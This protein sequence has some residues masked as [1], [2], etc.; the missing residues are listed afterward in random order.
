MQLLVSYGLVILLIWMANR[1]EV[2]KSLTLAN[3][4]EASRSL[5][6][7]ERLLRGVML[8]ISFFM[9]IYGLS[10][11]WG[12]YRK[13]VFVLSDWVVFAVGLVCAVCAW[14]LL[15]S[16]PM[17]LSL[18]HVF[19]HHYQPR[20][21]VHL[22]A[23]QIMIYAVGLSFIDYWVGGGLEGL[24]NQLANQGISWLDLVM[25]LFLFLS[26]TVIGV[27]LGIRR[28]LPATLERLGLRVPTV[29]DWAW[30]ILTAGFCL[31][32]L[33]NFSLWN[34]LVTSSAAVQQQAIA[35][36][37]LIALLGQSYYM[38]ALASITA[39]LGE[40]LLFRGALQ[41]VF[42]ILPTA[43]FFGLL[44]SQYLFTPPLLLVILLGCVL[45]FLRRMRNTTS[46]IIAHFSYNFIQFAVFIL[47]TKLSTDPALMGGMLLERAIW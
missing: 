29:G 19:N 14:V 33:I 3:T 25:Q 11:V 35:S 36:N 30:G 26:V 43:I 34:Q 2:L 42:G 24:A 9:P 8:V 18:K 15:W 44:H 45:G 27:G 38:A 46:A 41:P 12:N 13:Q 32:L 17:R 37:Q 6:S 5:Y 28:D 10:Y 4:A 16:P 23:V 39:G 7:T 20:S 22:M 47:F 40:E 31:S 21:A 1:T